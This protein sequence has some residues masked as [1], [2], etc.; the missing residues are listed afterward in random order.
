MVIR[1]KRSIINK[2]CKELHLEEYNYKDIINFDCTIGK[3]K[4]PYVDMILRKR[5]KHINSSNDTHSK[6][7]IT[8]RMATRIFFAYVSFL[9]KALFDGQRIRIAHVGVIYLHTKR[10]YSTYC[11]YPKDKKRSKE[12]G[13][14]TKIYCDYDMNSEKFRYRAPYWTFG[15]TY[16]KKLHDLEDKG[17]KY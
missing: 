11:G 17:Y 5:L 2:Q 4:V 12:M 10:S 1:T 7:N 9:V 3:R 16:K 15:S 6:S 8:Y 13:I 14:Y